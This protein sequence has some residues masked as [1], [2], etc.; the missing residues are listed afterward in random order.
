MMVVYHYE[1]SSHCCSDKEHRPLT[2]F[3]YLVLLCASFSRSCNLCPALFI[4]DVTLLLRVFLGLPLPRLPC[5]FYCRAWRVMEFFGFRNV[6]PI[7]PHFYCRLLHFFPQ[8]FILYLIR[9]S[10]VKNTSEAVV[11][12]DL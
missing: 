9:P 8:L 4:T 1:R 2:I 3:L 7:H 11:G 10:D 12:E 5:G 6:Y